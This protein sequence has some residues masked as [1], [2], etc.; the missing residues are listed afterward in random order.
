MKRT[1]LS[2]ILLLASLAP[3]GGYASIDT[4][5]GCLATNVNGP[6]TCT[7]VA[8]AEEGTTDAGVVVLGGRVSWMGNGE[9]V[10]KRFVACGDATPVRTWTTNGSDDPVKSN[11]GG[12]YFG[13]CY[14][15]TATRRGSNIAIGSVYFTQ[16]VNTPAG[17]TAI[18]TGDTDACFVS[19][20]TE[21]GATDAGVAVI[22]GR[23]SWAGTGAFLIQRFE[24]CDSTVELA[25]WEYDGS[26]PGASN[27]GG[28]YFG[29]C[30][31]ATALTPGSTVS[32]GPVSSALLP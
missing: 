19:A 22:G 11:N 1:I 25:R 14:T 7:V 23:V 6:D 13:Y 17:C 16:A 2:S 12:G 15:A 27:N 4:P 10:V 20:G 28:G 24:T 8:G 3:V 30:Y 32:L 26:E 9:F 21:E 18:N 29:F 5:I 31:K